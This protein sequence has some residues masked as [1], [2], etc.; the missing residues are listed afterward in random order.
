[1]KWPAVP[2]FFSGLKHA[3]LP[4]SMCFLY[5]FF[6]K[7]TMPLNQFLLHMASTLPELIFQHAFINQRSDE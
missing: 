4:H 6:T 1:M 5:N 3:Q 7:Q 2:V